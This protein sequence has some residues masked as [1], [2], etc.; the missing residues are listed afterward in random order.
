MIVCTL[1]YVGVSIV[2][3]GMMK[4]TTFVSGDAAAAPVAYA[5]QVLGASRWTRSVI[6]VGALTGMISSL[7]VFQYGQATHLVRDV[8]R[9]AIPED[10]LRG[11]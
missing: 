8:A 2:L 4:Y 6:I 10:V 11:P 1:L 3:L 9:R 5:L 7:L